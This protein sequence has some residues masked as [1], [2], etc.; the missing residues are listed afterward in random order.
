MMK[1]MRMRRKIPCH[2]FI[3]GWNRLTHTFITCRKM[4]RIWESQLILVSTFFVLK[5]LFVLKDIQNYKDELT[6]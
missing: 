3:L 2:A 5:E 4:E 1:H 6:T